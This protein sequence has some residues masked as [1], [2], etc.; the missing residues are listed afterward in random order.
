MTRQEKADRVEFLLQPL[1]WRP[2]FNGWQPDR[3]IGGTAAERKLQ[4]A[5]GEHLALALRTRENRVGA[6]E[7]P[8]PIGFERIECARGNQAFK[9][10]LVDSARIDAIGEIG[11]VSK[12]AITA[13]L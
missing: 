12:W 1:G 11:Q 9:H 6:A 10:A 5:A 13:R 8:C 7:C 2:G 3:L 4:G